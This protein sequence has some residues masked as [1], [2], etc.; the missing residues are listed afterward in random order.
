MT[1]FGPNLTHLIDVDFQCLSNRHC[2]HTVCPKDWSQERSSQPGPEKE[3]VGLVAGLDVQLLKSTLLQPS[4]SKSRKFF[5]KVANPGAGAVCQ[6]RC[7]DCVARRGGSLFTSLS[8]RPTQLTQ[9]TRAAPHSTR[10]GVIH[11]SLATC[12]LPQR[13]ALSIKWHS[14]QAI[15]P[16]VLCLL[17]VAL[18]KLDCLVEL[19]CQLLG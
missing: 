14:R 15:L 11:C 9:L 6:V 10:H 12:H 3:R 8:G 4:T 13:F 7:A 5:L 1:T 17:F 18:L 2:L 19:G 16:V